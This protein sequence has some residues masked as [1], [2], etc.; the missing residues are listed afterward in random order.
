MIDEEMEEY[1]LDS[2]EETDFWRVHRV[3]FRQIQFEL[4]HS[5]YRISPSPNRYLAGLSGDMGLTL[6]WRR[7]GSGDCY[8]KV[9]E[10][11]F[12]R[13]SGDSWWRVCHESFRLLE[14]VSAHIWCIPLGGELR[15]GVGV[16]RMAHL[17]DTFR[18]GHG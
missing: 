14:K 2:S 9:S 12:M 5:S 13:C 16:E 7:I 17:E 3:F 1:L 10:I 6:V 11:I 15:P 4:E 8:V 18:E